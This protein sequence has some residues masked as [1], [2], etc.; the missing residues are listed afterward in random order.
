MPRE[1]DQ[2]TSNRTFV[3]SAL[4]NRIRLDGRDFLQGRDHELIFGEDLGVVECRLG[5]TRVIAVVNGVIGRPQRADK[6]YEGALTIHSE[7]S[8]MTAPIYDTS[9]PTDEEVL[10][11]RMLDKVLRRSLAVDR[12]SLCILAG[13]RVWNLK[14]TFHFLSDEGNML[15]CAC[16]AGIVA[17]RHYRRPD[18]EVVG[19][20][21]IVHDPAERAPLPLAIHH[22][23]I[24][25]T[26]AFF[27]DSANPVVDPTHLETVLSSSRLHIA[28]THL[29]STSP[30]LC[31]LQKAGGLPLSEAELKKCVDVAISRAKDLAEWLEAAIAKDWEKRKVVVEVR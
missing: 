21:L 18:V 12:E 7:L 5:K 20:E 4:Q 8:P 2:P 15:D 25:V 6:P 13:Q 24:C 27:E 23:P 11:T 29:S 26:F 9:R 31:V 3:L 14:L 30:T 28:L 17:L 16:L 19:E 1:F 22:I 10:I